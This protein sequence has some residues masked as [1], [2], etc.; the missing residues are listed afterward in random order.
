MAGF[1]VSIQEEVLGGNSMRGNAGSRRRCLLG[2]IAAG[3]LI[4]VGVSAAT[5]S[6]AL[7]AAPAAFVRKVEDHDALW[8]KLAANPGTKLPV[9]VQFEM[10]ALPNAAGFELPEAADGARMKAIHASQDEFAKM[11]IQDF[12]LSVRTSLPLHALLSSLVCM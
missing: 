7:D 1:P 6:P 2:A 5:S 8:A 10:P 12:I 4:G 3:M 9:I 11:P